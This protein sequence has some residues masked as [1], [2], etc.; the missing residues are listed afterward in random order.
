MEMGPPNNAQVMGNPCT[1]RTRHA[2]VVT[3]WL[4]GS[5]VVG[6]KVSLLG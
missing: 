1:V 2:E 4:G 6:R 5:G 3:H